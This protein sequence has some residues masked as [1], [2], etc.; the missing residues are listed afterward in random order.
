M[1]KRLPDLEPPCAW[2]S[3]DGTRW[4]LQEHVAREKHKR[5]KPRGSSPREDGGGYDT[6]SSGDHTHQVCEVP[7]LGAVAV[8]S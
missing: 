2:P 6:G 5:G 7:L 1:G 8:F 4:Q 3:L